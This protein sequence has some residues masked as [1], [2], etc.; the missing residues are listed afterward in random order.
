[1]LNTSMNFNI[2]NL[3]QLDNSIINNSNKQIYNSGDF[4][5]MEFNV[6]NFDT[7]NKENCNKKLR[8][9]TKNEASNVANTELEDKNNDIV[10][11]FEK[12]L[13]S[14]INDDE[15]LKLNE[16][17]SFLQSIISL[18]NQTEILDN[19]LT[20][21]DSL[22][23]VG[24]TSIDVKSL[25]VLGRNFLGNLHS[26]SLNSTEN[27]IYNMDDLSNISNSNNIAN[28]NINSHNELVLENNKLTLEHD[29]E[30]TKETLIDFTEQLSEDFLTDFNNIDDIQLKKDILIEAFKEFILE[31]NF[32]S[33]T[34]DD[35]LTL[36]SSYDTFKTNFKLSMDKNNTLDNLSLESLNS[37]DMIEFLSNSNSVETTNNSQTVE[38]NELSNVILRQDMFSEDL[39][40]I[41][42]QM[43]NYNLRQ[44][45]IKLSPREL[46]D[47]IIDLSQI[48]ETSNIK[49][50]VSNPE[51]LDLIKSNLNEIKEY[52]KENHIISDSSTV[53]V[54]ADT[55]QRE[56]FNS[57]FESF[58]S[59]KEKRGSF[60]NKEDS[61]NSFNQDVSKNKDNQSSILNI[62]A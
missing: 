44:L 42:L 40:N 56:S 54:E 15:E 8:D 1:M 5:N 57:N 37:V 16:D 12:V 32:S 26:D 49:L 31:Y 50:T 30:T 7:L 24:L 55:S 14:I 3:K 47:M 43:K 59:N 62:L 58:A 35:S 51:T 19:S 20:K 2:L 21:S 11:S 23:E 48:K 61:D 13:D 22:D 33:E 4:M 39:E 29:L 36:D 28:Y 34:T 27:I 53:T 52:L 41:L 10:S 38:S 25:N 60:T 18:F 9:V 17:T 45:K 46:G 6:K